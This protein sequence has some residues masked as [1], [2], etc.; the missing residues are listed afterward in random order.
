VRRSTSRLAA[1]PSSE[2]PVLADS[3]EKLVQKLAGYR[4]AALT[5]SKERM[6]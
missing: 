4:Y 2:P 6:R 1:C 5:L 3:V